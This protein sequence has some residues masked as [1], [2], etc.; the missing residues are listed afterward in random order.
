MAETHHSDRARFFADVEHL[1]SGLRDGGDSWEWGDMS[2]AE[3]AI[4]TR[5][6][7][8]DRVKAVLVR[9]ESAEAWSVY[10]A[11]GDRGLMVCLTGN[12]PTSKAHAEFFAHAPVVI[13]T[14]LAEVRQL[15]A[16]VSAAE[17]RATARL[18][19]RI[20]ELASGES[21]VVAP[22]LRR[23]VDV[24]EKEQGDV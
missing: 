23:I 16:N 6:E 8:L 20:R 13:R 1:L 18:I 4:A 2:T 5:E 7:M 14:L 17:Q 19:A 9:R 12:G 21:T 3:P 24:L 11:K 22:S 10:I 15:E